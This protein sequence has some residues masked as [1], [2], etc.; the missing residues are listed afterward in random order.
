MDMYRVWNDIIYIYIWKIKVEKNLGVWNIN[1]MFKIDI[2]V[3]CSVYL[4][5]NIVYY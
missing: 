4:I 2:F 5:Y 3:K 1:D